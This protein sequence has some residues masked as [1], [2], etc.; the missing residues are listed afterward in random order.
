[1]HTSADS[2][3]PVPFAGSY[4]V[5]PGQLLAGFYPGSAAIP[6]AEQ[7]LDALIN[8]GI[9]CVVNLVEEEETGHNGRP[10]R[11]CAAPLAHQ[12]AAA[13]VEVTY[14]RIPVRDLSVPPTATMQAIL[15]ALD[16]AAKRCQ[17]MYLHC[18]G[19]RGRTGTVVGCW[20]ARHGLAVGDGAL[21]RLVE[22]RKH[23]AT[24][25]QPSPDTEAQ[26]AMVRGWSVGQ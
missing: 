13:G 12:A 14:M 10:L 22:L 3:V 2:S 4:W 21:Q 20:L 11:P 15:D 24:A 23:E 7:K 25:G 18:W 26:C 9:R 5:V 17:P 1:M 16:A 19:G 6:E 8:A